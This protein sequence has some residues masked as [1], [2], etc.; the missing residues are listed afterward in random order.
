M[1]IQIEALETTIS[2]PLRLSLNIEQVETVL[3]YFSLNDFVV[4]HGSSAMQSIVNLLCVH[5]QLPFQL[6]GLESNVNNPEIVLNFREH[7]DDCWKKSVSCPV[8]M[9]IN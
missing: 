2:W 1:S 6:G 3:P 4:L 8:K 7:F 9:V 5:V